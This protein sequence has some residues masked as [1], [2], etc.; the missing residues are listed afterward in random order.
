MASYRTRSACHLDIG[1]KR[2]N[3]ARVGRIGG[4]GECAVPE[5]AVKMFGV[6]AFDALPRTETVVDRPPRREKSRKRTHVIGGS[7]AVAKADGEAREA[8]LVNLASVADV[9]QPLGDG[10]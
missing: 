10:V 5:F 6:D 2:N 4:D 1:A 8:G 7:A 3:I 9:F